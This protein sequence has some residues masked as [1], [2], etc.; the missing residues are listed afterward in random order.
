MK[1]DELVTSGTL[2]RR[3]PRKR[4]GSTAVLGKTGGTEMIIRRVKREKFLMARKGE[5]PQ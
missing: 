1:F 4:N 5:H 2:L 3:S